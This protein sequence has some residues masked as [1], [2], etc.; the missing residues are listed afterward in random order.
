MPHPEVSP[1]EVADRISAYVYGNI[2]T[3][4]ALVVLHT[5]EVENGAGLAIVVG[6]ALSTFVA[7][8]Y[9]ESLGGAARGHASSFGVVL[10]DS[11]P[12]MSAAAVPAL[13]M[14]AGAL[15]WF[16]PTVCL[17]IAETWVVV[18]LALTG[19]IVGRL[20]GMPVTFHTWV[21]SIGLAAVA[22]AIVAVKVVLTH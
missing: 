14:L 20:R 17:R 12:I 9:A 2:L 18:R 19:F 10:R 11:L 4:A 21:A 5:D 7:H 8:A 16:S 13:L 15:E 1:D 3:L 22:L 6:T